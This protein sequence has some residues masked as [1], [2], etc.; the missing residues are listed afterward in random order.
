MAPVL[1]PRL[2]G[3]L[4]VAAVLTPVLGVLLRE[5]AAPREPF[6]GDRAP[7]AVSAPGL[8]AV[9]YDEPSAGRRA[10][11][12]R[13]RPG[14][15]PGYGAGPPGHSARG[16]DVRGQDAHEH[17]AHGSGAREDHV[18]GERGYGEPNRGE[19]VGARAAR[20]GGPAGTPG[21]GAPL[22]DVLAPQPPGGRAHTSGASREGPSAAEASR[23]D[24]EADPLRRGA[25]PATPAASAAGPGDSGTGADRESGAAG[26][27]AGA[28]DGAED[29]AEDEGEVTTAGRPAQGNAGA[30]AA[31][32]ARTGG[33][34][35]SRVLELGTGLLC[36][37]LGLGFFGLRLRRG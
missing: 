12:G 14:R 37:G 36:M 2:L 13:A 15:P 8:T 23:R 11:E 20:P 17:A 9:R 3:L 32:T 5:G 1:R 29:G 6:T 28:G 34:P 18:H 21:A 10:A 33:R 25:A 7:R 27:A 35:G 16:Q 24:R 4:L 19:E 30:P 31:A 26:A 22:A